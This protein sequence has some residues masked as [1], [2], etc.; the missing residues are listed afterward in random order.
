[1]RLNKT[2]NSVVRRSAILTAFAVAAL[3]LTGSL[4][5]AEG[6]HDSAASATLFR[7][8]CAM[9]HGPDGA[10]SEVGKSLNIPDLRS[11]AVQKLPNAEL[12][13]IISNAKGGIPSFNNSLT[14]DQILTLLIHIPS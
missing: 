11:P 4:L 8:K 5:R 13:E 3:A 7:S 14:T 10:G 2:R 9:C 1:M 6:A 12:F